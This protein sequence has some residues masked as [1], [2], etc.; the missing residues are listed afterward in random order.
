MTC[1]WTS[2]LSRPSL[3]T[4]ALYFASS[5]TCTGYLLADQVSKEL[6]FF[7]LWLPILVH[8]RP[9]FPRAQPESF[10]GPSLV[11]PSVSSPSTLCQLCL[12]GLFRNS[13]SS[14]FSSLS[15]HLIISWLVCSII[16]SYDCLAFNLVPYF[17]HKIKVSFKCASQSL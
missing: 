7:S 2:T 13:D 6:H 10:S 14:H 11:I 15:S 5:N 1:Q 16:M 4:S 8:S 9:S 3:L 12:Q 17:K